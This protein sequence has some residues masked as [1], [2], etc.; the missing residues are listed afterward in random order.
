MSILSFEEVSKLVGDKTLF[1]RISFGMDDTDKLGVIG[2]NG[3][4]K[5]TLLKIIAG[6]EPPD[7][8]RVILTGNKAVMYLPQNPPFNPE[9]TVLEAVLHSQSGKM[10][11]IYDY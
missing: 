8:G 2:A 10:K 9:Q 11:L 1:D 4:G 7:S 3:S 5:S 6:I